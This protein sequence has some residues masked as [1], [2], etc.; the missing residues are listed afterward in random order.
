MRIVALS[1]ALV[2]FVNIGFVAAQ[3]SDTG[4]HNWLAKKSSTTANNKTEAKKYTCPM[5]TD[6][7]SNKPG[8]CPNCGM[9]LQEVAA[10]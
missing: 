9:K 6:V 5:C 1:I 3:A 2:A 7:V 4:T 10:K 8:N